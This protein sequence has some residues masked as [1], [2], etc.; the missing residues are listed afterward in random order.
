MK[1]WS[2]RL[3]PVILPVT[4]VALVICLFFIHS[5]LPD[6]W[7]WMFWPIFLLVSVISGVVMGVFIKR[8]HQGASKDPL[9]GL[10][11]RRCFYDRMN[12]E[13]EKMKR[14]KL[15]LSLA[16]VDIDNFKG[17]NDTYGHLEGDR[18]LVQLAGI[19]KAQARSGDTIV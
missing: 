5:Y 1:A 10:Y 4:G 18:V 3:A 19:F 12:Y 8:L 6:N 13:M 17:I 2:Y 15:P 16:L 7:Q 11:N 14:T 9:T